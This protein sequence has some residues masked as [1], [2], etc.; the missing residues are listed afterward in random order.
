MRRDITQSSFQQF[1]GFTTGSSIVMIVLGIL[2]LALPAFTGLWTAI[3]IGSL[4]VLGGFAR[5]AYAFA[6]PRPGSFL[7]RMLSGVAFVIGRFYLL[8]HPGL[9]LV[10]FTLLLAVILFGE[11][12]AE[13]IA[14]FSLRALPGSSWILFNAVLSFFLG[15]MIWRNWP[16]SSDWAIGTLVGANLITTGFTRLMYVGTARRMASDPLMHG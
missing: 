1:A 8:I 14:F 11:S 13:V 12:V 5:F 4:I 6:A 10:S 16:S 9:S 7:W 3:V 15:A 2:A